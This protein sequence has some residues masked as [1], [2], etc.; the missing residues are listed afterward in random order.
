MTLMKSE[1][2][3]LIKV[4]APLNI[5]PEAIFT[6]KT[7]SPFNENTISFASL[8]S[9][10]L[11][12]DPE[13]KLKPE[14]V[15]LAYWM[16]KTNILQLKEKFH[17]K[18]EFPLL[19][20]GL[21]FHIAPS[22]VDTI[23]IYSLFLSIFCGNTNV[24]RLSSTLNPQVELLIR[25][26]NEC[27]N[28]SPE[29]ARQVLLIRYDHN[30]EITADFSAQSDL[31]IIWGG[32]ETIR[33]I[34]RFPL[35]PHAKELTFA[36]RFSLSVIGSQAYL[37]YEHKDKL[38]SAFYNDSY[39]FN[40]MACSSP[41][42]VCWVDENEAVSI[43]AQT[44]FWHRLE[45]YVMR[46]QPDIASAALMD[47]YLSQCIYAIETDGANSAPSASKFIARMQLSDGCK[48][49]RELHKGN[50]LFL[51]VHLKE[52]AGL[53]KILDR[54][55]QTMTAFGFS[56]DVLTAFVVDNLPKGIDRIVPFGEALAFSS[57]WDGYDLLLEMTRS[58][59][60]K[61]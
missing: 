4:E 33:R 45:S 60:I 51:E 12:R 31:R 14:L 50:G 2:K 59:S 52:L 47:K 18:S 15:A 35:P 46:Q 37:D 36:D 42:L 9:R 20:R 41:R 44:D 49:K 11:L 32:D 25:V 8:F 34:R 61:T 24:V 28:E 40:Q 57:L 53:L 55:D 48:L 43:A 7:V 6:S 21:A 29:V 5:D 16:R 58:V 54:K 26:L 56:S 17:Q 19:P 3:S 1:F 10:Y 23:F 38:T 13:A 39:L 30:D 22:N 27:F